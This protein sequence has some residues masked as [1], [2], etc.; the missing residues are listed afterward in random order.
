MDSVIS[1]TS[2]KYLLGII[3]NCKEIDNVQKW[4]GKMKNYQKRRGKEIEGI[5]ILLGQRISCGKGEKYN[6]VATW[7]V[8][9]LDL[10]I[11]DELITWR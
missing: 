3:G 1:I 4:N 2:L 9:F 7:S 6:S 5:R 10:Q 8:A 11:L